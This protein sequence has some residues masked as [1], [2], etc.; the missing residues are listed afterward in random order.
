MANRL[1][2]ETSPYL[3]QHKNNP[4][5]WY[6]WGPEALLRAREQDMPIMLSIGYSA[7][8]W[9]HVMEHESFEDEETAKVMNALFV[10]IKVDRE[11]RPDLDSIYTQA[12]QAMTGRGGW[13]MTVFLTPDGRPFFGGTYFPKDERPGMPAFTRVLMAAADAYHNKRADVLEGADQLVAKIQ[14]PPVEQTGEMMTTL[15]L[16]TAAQRVRAQFDRQHG[17]FGGAPKF[18]QS[19]GL[20]V[21]LRCSRRYNDADSL[22]MVELTLEKMARGGMYDQVG[23][24]F[25]RYSTDARWLVPHFEKMLYDNALLSR[26]YLHAY[27]LTGKPFYRDVAE[28]TF[29]YVLRE[30]TSPEGGFYSSQDA[31]SEG[32]E[33]KFFVWRPQEIV[34]VLGQEA[35][36]AFMRY[37]DVTEDGNFEGHNILHVPDGPAAVAQELGTSEESLAAV[38]DLAKKQLLLVRERR[39]HPGRD[40]KVL[41]A[42]NGLMLRSFAEGAAALEREDY[43]QAAV[44]NADFLLSNL[45]RDGRLRRTYKDGQAKLSGY[46]E[47]YAMLA[48]GL[49]ALYEATFDRRWLDEARSLADTMVAQFW[50]AREGVFYDTA[51]DHEALIVRPRDTFDNAMPCG[52]SVAADVLLRLS[53]LTGDGEYGRKAISALR[54]VSQYMTQYPNGFGRWLAALDFY[55]S[56][57][58][59]IAIVGPRDHRATRALRSVVFSAYLP[60]RVVAGYDPASGAEAVRG[61]PLL[62]G[63]GLVNGQPTAYVCEH[64]ACMAPVTDPEALRQQLGLTQAP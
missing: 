30:M 25:H 43:L 52:G 26:S 5:D 49:I 55:L 9:C 37:F 38:I 57:P 17:G 63:R 21:L 47:D 8:H 34:D 31:D 10:S 32:E 15:I 28:E 42:W 19:M 59:E 22:G 54:S 45:K 48:D 35:A 41:T 39:V 62:E 60:S 4:V 50:E 56:T 1:A 46:L 36:A 58:Q 13:P 18:P 23:G 27:Q 14:S 11:E 53:V 24:G 20:D 33:G 7:C 61:M 64:Y 29:G 40:D 2:G 51:R 3:L 16:Q 6:P 12:V 44:R